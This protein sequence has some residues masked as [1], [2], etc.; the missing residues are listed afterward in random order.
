M[1]LWFLLAK[2]KLFI[3]FVFIFLLIRH[4][5][6]DYLAMTEWENR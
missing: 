3:C 6:N 1:W 4:F 2:Y 5:Y